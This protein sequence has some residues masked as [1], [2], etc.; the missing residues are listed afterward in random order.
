MSTPSIRFNKQDNPEFFKELNDRVNNYFKDNKL[1]KHANFN[2]RFKTVF[3]LFLYFTPLAC[4]LTG[5]VT[6][7]WPVMLMWALM[8]FGVAGIGLAVMHDAN[9]GSYSSNPR[10]N[11]VVGFVMNFLGGF[12]TGGYS[13]T[14]CT[15][16]SPTYTDWTKISTRASCACRPIRNGKACSASRRSMRPSSI[17]S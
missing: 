5:V 3:M 1:S 14:C 6:T 13:T 8:G 4:M 9:H 10:T 11:A 15:T 2:M 17:P 16:P 12:P 7:L